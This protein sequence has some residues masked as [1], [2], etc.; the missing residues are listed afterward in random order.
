MQ[1]GCERLWIC[2]AFADVSRRV[3]FV[4]GKAERGEEKKVSA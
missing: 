3:S 2:F 4:W 1:N